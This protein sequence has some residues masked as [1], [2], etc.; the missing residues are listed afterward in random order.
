VAVLVK[1][2]GREA[3]RLFLC[4]TTG[5]RFQHEHFE[6]CVLLI[7]QEKDLDGEEAES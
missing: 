2:A 3:D 1:A 5:I 7:D 6:Y 4:H